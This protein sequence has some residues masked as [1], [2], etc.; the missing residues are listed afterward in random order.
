MPTTRSQTDKNKRKKISINIPEVDKVPK[1]NS[2]D[3]CPYRDPNNITFDSESESDSIGSVMEQQEDGAWGGG[4]PPSLE[5]RD[6][7]LQGT[8]QSITSFNSYATDDVRRIIEPQFVPSST[9]G[10]SAP[11]T[12]VTTTPALSAPSVISTILSSNIPISATTS[13]QAHTATS[14]LSYSNAP[15]ITNSRRSLEQPWPNIRRMSGFPVLEE[16]SSTDKLLITLM[17][18]LDSGFSNLNSNLN[19]LNTGLRKTQAMTTPVTDTIF[20]PYQNPV[21]S[22]NQNIYSNHVTSLNP[23]SAGPQH[24]GTSQNYDFPPHRNI[25][26]NHVGISNSNVSRNPVVSTHQYVIPNPVEPQRQNCEPGPGGI[27]HSVS[28]NHINPQIP[29]TPPAEHNPITRLE[30]MVTNLA[31][32]FQ[33]LSERVST[34]FESSHSSVSPNRSRNCNGSSHTSVHKPTP[35][36]WRIKYDGDNNKQSIEY[37]LNQIAILKE[38]TGA[39][40]ESVICWF[41]QYLE[42]EVSKWFGRYLGS[43]SHINWTDLRRDMIAEFKGTDTEQSIRKKMVKRKQTELETFDKFY[44]SLLDLQ[45]RLSKKFSDEEMI[46]LLRDNVKFEIQK[47]LITYTTT[48]LS[49]FVTKCRVTDK[50]LF[51]K[52]SEEPVPYKRRVSEIDNNL[53]LSSH[54]IEAFTAKR[55]QNSN[56]IANRQCWNC[57]GFG[58]GWQKCEAQRRIFCYYCGYKNVICHECPSC[59]ANFRLPQKSSDPPPSA[60]PRTD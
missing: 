14:A 13:T 35:D 19:A 51:Y 25:Y 55:Q 12:T 56:T 21:A 36:K 6:D 5:N 46:E 52:L 28:R 15:I 11:F 48:S 42:G 49:D 54:D 38:Y 17:Q 27:Q 8:P 3:R 1:D 59:Y 50:L 32:Q 16:E 34:N 31:F 33:N 60:P 47:C 10:A 18:K 29:N 4:L 44:N 7:V 24:P 43:H 23:N 9:T 57:D 30:R 37:F 40:W 53:D 58:H 39:S 22:Q 41:P 45:D 26:S 2:F 20:R